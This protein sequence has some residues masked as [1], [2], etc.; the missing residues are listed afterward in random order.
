MIHRK[1][2][3][4]VLSRLG[5][6]RADYFNRLVDR[7]ERDPRTET[8]PNLV[9][10]VLK[11]TIPYLPADF[12]ED[13]LA[14]RLLDFVIVNQGRLNRVIHDRR[15]MEDPGRLAGLTKEFV[16]QV[17]ASAMDQ[18][19]VNEIQTA[20][21]RKAKTYR[22]SYPEGDEADFPYGDDDE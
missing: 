14:D 20:K 12:P 9:Y 16:L 17:L 7:V 3:D 1:I 18:H 13:E 8:V 6:D 22:F 2:I 21:V 5:Q 10:L 19:Q 15:Y 11:E 4:P